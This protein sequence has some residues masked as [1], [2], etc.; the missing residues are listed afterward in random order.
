MITAIRHTGIVVEDLEKALSFYA[1]VLGFRLVRRAEESGPFI[2]RVLGLDRLRLTT[3][4]M[5]APD[6][7]LIELL[8]YHN[9]GG[10]R[11]SLQI[12]DLGITHIAVQVDDIEADYARLMSQGVDFTSPPQRSPDGK[13]IVAF[14]TAPEGTHIE[15]V[16]VLKQESSEPTP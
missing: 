11:K 15:F 12:N 4:K 9:H 10:R 3:V 16:Q 5:A 2:D 13:A 14:G 1:D 8:K 6:G 7:Q